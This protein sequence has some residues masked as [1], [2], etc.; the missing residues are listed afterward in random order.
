[1]E[2]EQPGASAPVLRPKRNAARY[3]RPYPAEAVPLAVR[4]TCSVRRLRLTFTS[5]NRGAHSGQLNDFLDHPPDLS[6][7][8]GH[9]EAAAA[10]AGVFLA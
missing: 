4:P 6:A 2:R 7:R 3:G 8:T 5:S 10:E 9:S 1:M